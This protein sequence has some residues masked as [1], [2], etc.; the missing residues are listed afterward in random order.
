[1]TASQKAM[2]TGL[3]QVVQRI[4]ASAPLR[5]LTEEEAASSCGAIAIR[6]RD[7]PN[8]SGQRNC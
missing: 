8:N 6:Y 5:Y 3:A 7:V 1:M 2:M 4:S